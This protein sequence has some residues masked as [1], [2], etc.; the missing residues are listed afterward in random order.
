MP[1]SPSRDLADRYIGNRGYFHASGGIR[2]LK[3]VLAAVAAV[4]V[5][6][7]ALYDRVG[8]ASAAYAHSHGPVANVH[9]AFDANCEA[10]HAGQSV[11]LNPL[12]VL[13][14]QKR[15]HDLTCQKCHAGP[16]HHTTMTEA[17]AAFEKRCENCHHDHLGRTNSL[18]RISD[19]HCTRCH[20]DL[21][22]NQV[23]GQTGYAAKVT[24]FV[25]DHPEFTPI[26]KQP[27][28]RLKF[29][30]SLHM[31]PGVVYAKDARGGFTLKDIPEGQRDRYRKGDQ[32]D[33]AAVQ[34]D[35]RSCHQ[36]D[37][38]VG[39]KDSLAA[40]FN[41]LAGQPRENI[42]LARAE[43]AYFLPVNYDAHCKACHPVK[44]PEA[45]TTQGATAKPFDLPHRV[46]LG[47]LKAAVRGGFTQRLLADKPELVKAPPFGGRLD[48]RPSPEGEAF[49]KEV[50]RLTAGAMTALTTGATPVGQAPKAVTPGEMKLPSGGYACGKCHFSDGAGEAM[51]IAPRDS[52]TVWFQHAKFGHVAH[53]GVRCD[54]CHPGTGSDLL[55]D[56]KTR[57]DEVEPLRV[58][59]IDTC[60]KCHAPAGS[61]NGS[62]VGGV[63][64]DCT[65][66]HRYHN[67]DNFLQGKGA[68]SRDATAPKSIDGWLRGGRD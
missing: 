48:P 24:S 13:D 4:G 41:L 8:P 66:C 20:A 44:T 18:V 58:L 64:Y 51:T 14:T 65:L 40:A 17:G 42:L 26:V 49:A 56:G 7:W 2:R 31:T 10:C 43:G 19:D 57:V 25:K 50:D 63:R 3:N 27:E 1:R 12:S 33:T 68:P 37:G 36:L 38:R 16:T 15:W 23:A 28:R 6:G 30:H 61:T 39:S 67:G 53:R 32:A 62:P 34:L 59:G 52:R 60:K 47:E 5:V 21:P 9:A 54:E 22:K 35:C 29:S 46:S 45:V 55:P 11:S